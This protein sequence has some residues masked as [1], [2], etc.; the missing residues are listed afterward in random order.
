M[1]ICSVDEAAILF[2]ILSGVVWFIATKIQQLGLGQAVKV[3]LLGTLPLIFLAGPV[4]YIVGVILALL[5]QI[6]IRWN[7]L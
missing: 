3:S 2:A 5:I 1:A 6:F 4:N 7:Y